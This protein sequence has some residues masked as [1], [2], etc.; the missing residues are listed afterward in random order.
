MSAVWGN[1]TQA[2]SRTPGLNPSFSSHIQTSSKSLQEKQQ[3]ATHFLNGD[4]LVGVLVSG[5]VN[6]GKLEKNTGITL[7]LW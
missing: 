5:L 6:R 1:S 4:D 2:G 7:G 3:T